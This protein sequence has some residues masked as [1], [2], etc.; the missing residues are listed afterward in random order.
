MSKSDFINFFVDKVSENCNSFAI[1]SINNELTTAR[2]LV[3]GD[4]RAPIRL[5]HNVKL[6][7]DYVD[8]GGLHGVRIPNIIGIN[9]KFRWNLVKEPMRLMM[10]VH[11]ALYI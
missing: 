4:K 6:L 1:I 2:V 3:K 10:L 5:C 7:L 8:I 11:V 9:D